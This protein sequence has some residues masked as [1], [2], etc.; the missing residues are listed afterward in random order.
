MQISELESYDV[1][2]EDAFPV[3]RVTFWV[4]PNRPAELADS[5]HPMAFNAE[6]YRVTGARDIDEV[7]QWASSDGRRFELFVEVTPGLSRVDQHGAEVLRLSGFNPAK[8][9]HAPPG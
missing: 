8:I 3:Y 7:L 9:A 2:G 4:A 5:P 1:A 6:R